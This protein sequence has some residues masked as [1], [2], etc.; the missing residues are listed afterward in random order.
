MTDLAQSIAFGVAGIG[1]GFSI[2]FYICDRYR[3][4]N[5]IGV[6]KMA[7]AC[8]AQMALAKKEAAETIE[9][10]SAMFERDALRDEATIRELSAAIG[11]KLAP[12]PP[13]HR[14]MSD[15]DVAARVNGA[16]ASAETEDREA[17]MRRGLNR[18]EAEAVQ[19]G[20]FDNLPPDSLLDRIATGITMESTKVV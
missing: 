5:P 7:A 9:R 6:D 3:R 15:E 19:R 4:A 2:G 14:T 1:W 18:T 13:P 11:M 20:E 16:V 10:M 17:L 8:T 12:Q